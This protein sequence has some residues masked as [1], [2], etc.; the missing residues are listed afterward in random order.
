MDRSEPALL[1]IDPPYLEIRDVERAI[2]LLERAAKS[3]WTVLW[4]QM[5]DVDAMPEICCNS[6]MYSVNF[7]DVGMSCGKWRGATMT[8]VGMTI[9]RIG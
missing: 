6:E 2:D 5:T 9:Y 4:W 7:S 8:V 1:L 3:G